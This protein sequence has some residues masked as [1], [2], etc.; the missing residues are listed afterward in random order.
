MRPTAPATASPSERHAD[1]GRAR[2][3]HLGGPERWHHTAV[4]VSPPACREGH[5]RQEIRPPDLRRV[6]LINGWGGRWPDRP[7][8]GHA[9]QGFRSPGL[10]VVLLINT[11]EGETRHPGRAT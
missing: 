6:L 7:D 5:V 2:V 1:R 3:D 8:E 10:R 4:G 11:A 9:R